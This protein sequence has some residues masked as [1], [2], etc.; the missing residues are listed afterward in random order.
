MLVCRLQKDW[1]AER[2]IIYRRWTV[3]SIALGNSTGHS[4]S[5]SNINESWQW[6]W[7]WEVIH[8]MHPVFLHRFVSHR[9]P[10]AERNCLTCAGWDPGKE[11][12]QSPL[13]LWAERTCLTCAAWDP[14]K[15]G[16]QSPLVLLA[17]DHLGILSGLS[18]QHS[19]TGLILFIA[20]WLLEHFPSLNFSVF[21]KESQS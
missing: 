9:H 21:W 19:H 12:L 6:Q 1:E 14:G 15:E 20:A 2:F 18:I 5:L 11:G 8:L 10:W 17:S 4:S 3:E 16:L 13:V 7:P